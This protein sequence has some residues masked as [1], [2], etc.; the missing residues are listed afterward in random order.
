MM[1]MLGALQIVVVVGSTKD[2]ALPVQHDETLQSDNVD[3]DAILKLLY[4][5]SIME[6]TRNVRRHNGYDADNDDDGDSGY[7][8]DI[9]DAMESTSDQQS[10]RRRNT[11]VSTSS[12]DEFVGEI[13]AS[14]K[15]QD[16]D[17]DGD[18]DDDGDINDDEIGDD[19]LYASLD[20][21][22]EFLPRMM[23]NP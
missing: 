15:D 18:S 13:I 22:H 14:N 3:P 7:D 21:L 6:S 1:M 20:Y 9:D 8:A 4:K 5:H 17:Y 12:K 23:N 11:G 19:F 10:L 2:L 16:S